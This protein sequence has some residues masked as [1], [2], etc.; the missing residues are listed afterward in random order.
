MSNGVPKAVTGAF[1]DLSE[2]RFEFGEGL[3]DRIE[4]GAVGWQVE[5]PGLPAFDGLRKAGDLVAGQ[6]VHDDNIARPQRRG[7]NLFDISPEDVTVHGAIEDIR[8]GDAGGAQTGDKSGGF[9]VT[10]GHRGQ[11]AQTSGASARAPGH[12]GC[13]RGL[14]EEHQMLRVESGL[15]P[16]E[17]V[18]GLGHVTT[19]LLSGV[20]A[21]FLRVML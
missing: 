17:G 1:A 8:G 5:Q 9:P 21:F 7:E 14:V 4:V 19:L 3:L 11:Q 2:Q 18:A 12:V 16:D 6:I 10:V 20:Q 13:R 15:A